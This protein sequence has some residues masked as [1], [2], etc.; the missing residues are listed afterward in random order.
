MCIFLVLAFFFR[1]F[2]K[3]RSS[4]PCA[5]SL[6]RFRNM[7]LCLLIFYAIT[8]VF[9]FSLAQWVYWG[10]TTSKALHQCDVNDMLFQA[11]HAIGE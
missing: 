11:A 6:R 8:S 7:L 5:I 1:F 4:P 9:K 3:S 2:A 10:S